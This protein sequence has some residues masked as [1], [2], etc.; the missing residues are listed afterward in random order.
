MLLNQSYDQGH[1]TSHDYDSVPLNGELCVHMVHALPVGVLSAYSAFLAALVEEE[2]QL[3]P[4]GLVHTAMERVEAV[5]V[6]EQVL[7]RAAARTREGREVAMTGREEGTTSHHKAAAGFAKCELLAL[8]L[9]ISPPPPL[10]C[11]MYSLFQKCTRLDELFVSLCKMHRP[12]WSTMEWLQSH[13][14]QSN[15]KY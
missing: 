14:L 12:T 11:T 6:Q 1:G 3:L 5:S 7:H 15:I 4:R 13:Q 10:S 9:M 8:L 2:L